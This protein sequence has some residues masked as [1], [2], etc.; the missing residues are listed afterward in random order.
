[1][2]TPEIRAII[3]LSWRACTDVQHFSNFRLCLGLFIVCVLAFC[4]A[5]GPL[6]RSYPTS[7]WQLDAVAS[8][9]SVLATARV[10][11]TNRGNSLSASPNRTVL[12]RAELVVLRAFPPSVLLPGQHIQL[13][14]EQLPAEHSP[15][16]GPDV[17]P[18]DARSVFIVPLKANPK[19]ESDAWRLIA[20]EGIGTVIPAIE[21]QF[22][23]P[24]QPKN[25]REYLLKEVA[26]GLSTGTR[27][28]RLREASYLT[29]QTTNGYAAEMMKL[30]DSAIHGDT[31]R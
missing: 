28:E 11:H 21:R 16:S 7:V 27:E 31:E 4:V 22:S 12:G 25:K 23:F 1:M 2:S 5:T 3:E 14:Y 15:G 9:A 18:L 13:E 30:L 6:V 26:A 19:P 24:V 29:H 20:D 10:E 8:T 17:P